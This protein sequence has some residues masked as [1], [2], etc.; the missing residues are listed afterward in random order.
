MSHVLF[1]NVFGHGHINPTIGLVEELLERGEKVTYIAG[2]E[3]RSRIENLGAVFIGYK[4]F[5]ELEFN[6][7]DIGLTEMEPQLMEIARVYI[8]II[9]TV[10]SIEERF[11]CIIYDLLFFLGAEIAK[12]LKVPAISSNSTFAIN[13]KT[14]YLSDFFARFGPAVK[15][16]L[17][18]PGFTPVVR[19]LW[20]KYGIEVPDLFSL[21]SLKNDINIVYTSKYFQICGNSFDESYKFIGP[22][23]PDRREPMEPALLEHHRSKTIYIS[24]G[25]IFNRSVEFYKSCL[26]AFGD[27]DARIIMSVGRN[28][29]MES[30][31]D[32]PENFVIMDHVPQLEVLKHADLFITHGGMNSANESL[33]Y[34]VP[35]I[36]VPH[37]FDQPI[38]AYRVAELGA[39]IVIEKDKVSPERLKEA[40]VS[41]FSNRGY[42]QNSEKA[43]KTLRAAGGYKRGVDEILNIINSRK[44]NG[45]L[46]LR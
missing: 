36:A 21:H 24:L 33:Y 38:V 3:F 42:R 37:F 4:N 26:A 6:N 10:F 14:N 22:S 39:G 8:G 5:N 19:H 1:I 46:I 11:D 34:S 9:E 20:D 7:G 31:R 12:V 43:G 18:N 17:N 32:I 23:I 41:I 29:N 30:F 27:M 13:D 45:D 28:I 40:A 35:L 2:E 25:T 15:R 44:L 16:L